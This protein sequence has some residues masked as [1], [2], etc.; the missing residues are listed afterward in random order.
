MRYPIRCC[1]NPGRVLGTLDIHAPGSHPGD[2]RTVRTYSVPSLSGRN[3]ESHPAAPG[4]SYVDLHFER[5]NDGQG[6]EEWAI[7]SDD[8]PLEFWRTMKGWHEI[9]E[10]Y[11]F[12]GTWRLRDAEVCHLLGVV[13]EPVA[14]AGL[15]EFAHSPVLRDINRRRNYA[16][17]YPSVRSTAAERPDAAACYATGA[18][19]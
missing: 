16:T 14:Y 6:A 11:S 10:E 12:V 7:K 15:R 18:W 9:D 13:D 4:L 2:P 19:S 8:R 1:C 5:F 17:R 3:P